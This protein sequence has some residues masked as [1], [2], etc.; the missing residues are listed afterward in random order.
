MYDE[1]RIEGNAKQK[2]LA[3]RLPL[4]GLAT[5]QPNRL[6]YPRRGRVQEFFE[7]NSVYNV[8]RISTWCDVEQHVEWQ[9]LN[10][11]RS[12]SPRQVRHLFSPLRCFRTDFAVK[13][14]II[15]LELIDIGTA[16]SITSGRW[17]S[18]LFSMRSGIRCSRLRRV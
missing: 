6:R 5:H 10:G 8:V 13:I 4:V 18:V 7:P 17:S 16:R 1:V 3:A 11:P 9:S 2:K 15:V 14:A 12:W